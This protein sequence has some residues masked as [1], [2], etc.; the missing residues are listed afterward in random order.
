MSKKPARRFKLLMAAI[1]MIGVS[2]GCREGDK[3]N[4]Y[5][6]GFWSET[7]EEDTIQ[8]FE[9][10]AAEGERPYT[11][12]MMD[13]SEVGFPTSFTDECDLGYSQGG[14]VTQSIVYTHGELDVAKCSYI[15]NGWDPRY[16]PFLEEDSSKDNPPPYYQWLQRRFRH[17][18]I[19]GARGC[20][21][22]CMDHLEKTGR[23][24]KA[25]ATPMIEGRQWVIDRSAAGDS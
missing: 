1:V 6:E 16:S 2:L 12:D 21:R 17:Q 18:S 3:I 14:N 8:F 25:Y 22:A 5:L 24:E 13:E 4:E 23:I 9:D 7:T 20:V 19:C 11:V 10:V 15:H